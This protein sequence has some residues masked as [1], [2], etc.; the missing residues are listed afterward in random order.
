[1]DGD[2]FAI[3]LLY[4]GGVGVMP[5]SSF[6]QALQHWVRISLTEEDDKFDGACRRIVRYVKQSTAQVTA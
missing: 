5:G 3:D 1:M 2:A 6:G 4:N